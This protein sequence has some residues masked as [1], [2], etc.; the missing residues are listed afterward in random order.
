[1]AHDTTDIIETETTIQDINKF[2]ESGLGEVINGQPVA[3][4]NATFLAILMQQLG[5]KDLTWDELTA[6]VRHASGAIVTYL[7]GLRDTSAPN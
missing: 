5:P 7:S 1:M 6:G 4:I 2:L 3:L